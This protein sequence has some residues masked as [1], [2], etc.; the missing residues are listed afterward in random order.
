MCISDPALPTMSIVRI[1]TKDGPFHCA[2]V[3]ACAL[4]KLLPQ[5]KNA[6][7]VRSQDRSVL[8]N[9]D[10]VVGVGGEYDSPRHRYDHHVREFQES[11]STIIKKSGY[12]WT[13][14]LSSAGLIYCHFGHDILKRILS[15]VTK[16][17]LEDTIVDEI[18]KIIYD[19]FIQEI[20][21]IDNNGQIYRS[22]T[23]LSAR[24]SRLN[25]QDENIET[26]FEKAIALAQNEFLEIFHVTKNIWLPSIIDM[27]C[28]IENR[29]EVDSSGEIVMV[30]QLSRCQNMWRFVFYLAEEMNVSP[31]IKYA[32]SKTGNS[33]RIRCM[34]DSRVSSERAMLLPEAWG[35]LKSDAL[36]KVCGI[37]GAI[38]VDSN[39]KTGVH[40]TKDG[41]MAMARKALKIVKTVQDREEM[42]PLRQQN[43]PQLVPQVPPQPPQASGVNP[44]GPQQ[45]QQ[46]QP[47]EQQQ[48]QSQN[49]AGGEYH[50]T[51]TNTP[52]KTE[53]NDSENK[54][55]QQTKYNLCYY[56]T[57]C[58]NLKK[59][60]FI[61]S[62][63]NFW[64]KCSF[65][66]TLQSSNIERQPFNLKMSTDIK[67]K[68]I[69][70][71]ICLTDN[72]SKA[73]ICIQVYKI[74]IKSK[75]GPSAIVSDWKNFFSNTNSLYDVSLETLRK[76]ES[77]YLSNNTLSICF[78]FKT[79]K[80][81]LLHSSMNDFTSDDS[82]ITFV[83]EGRECL[84]KR[85][86][87]KNVNNTLFKDIIKNFDTEK[88]EKEKLM[89]IDK[90]KYDAFAIGDTLFN[91]KNIELFV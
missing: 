52:E 1:G 47:Q 54:D 11:V 19:T 16:D 28:A 23:D 10:I 85:W 20:D 56:R 51:G 7:I 89:L 8:D 29:F 41:A 63:S 34:P 31:S 49:N 50:S 71:S 62:I 76:D 5:Y 25:Y 4:L 27:R 46:Q 21:A 75:K 6:S 88:S 18:F 55:Q 65:A 68:K 84:V 39:R 79:C 2:E 22:I 26:Q 74:Y 83:I 59:T 80:D 32:I 77:K 81:S 38:R 66:E 48:Q 9:C 12:N 60:T 30:P 73:K 72:K 36:V 58:N 43:S 61:W 44:I 14:R 24:V 87:L 64:E 3:L 86:I 37:E 33:Y 40:K 82:K 35:G 57:K 17:I 15:D 13:N 53:D 67:N 45:Q 78:I 69:S 91:I 42:E 70:F 90:V